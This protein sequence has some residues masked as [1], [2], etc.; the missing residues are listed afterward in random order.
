MVH[1]RCVAFCRSIFTNL[2]HTA[3][4][5]LSQKLAEEFK[6]E[7][8]ASAEAEEPESLTAFKKRGVWEVGS[9]GILVSSVLTFL[10][11]RVSRA[12]TK[13]P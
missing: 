8:D 6:Y 1:V 5:A 2:T 3:D 4:L 10:R 9:S 13:W 11:L 12:V 7:Q